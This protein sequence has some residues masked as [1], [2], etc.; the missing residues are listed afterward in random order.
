MDLFLG[1]HS[2]NLMLEYGIHSDN[3]TKPQLSVHSQTS[4]EMN[5]LQKEMSLW[6]LSSQNSQSNK[7]NTN[8]AFTFTQ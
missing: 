3:T 6:L 4:K 2:T 5:R 8:W 1:C 7:T